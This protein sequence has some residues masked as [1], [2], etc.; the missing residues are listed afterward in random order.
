[1]QIRHL[2][3][4]TDPRLLQRAASRPW[5]RALSS[6]L[7]TSAVANAIHCAQ[8]AA[9][10]GSDGSQAGLYLAAMYVAI[11]A[12]SRMRRPSEHF[13]PASGA[14]F[15]SIRTGTCFRTGAGQCPLMRCWDGTALQSM[16]RAWPSGFH[17]MKASRAA[18]C[19]GVASPEAQLPTGGGARSSMG[20]ASRR[21]I[22]M[23]WKDG[24]KIL[25]CLRTGPAAFTAYTINT[26]NPINLTFWLLPLGSAP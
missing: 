9:R 16:R 11:A 14:S 18:A 26:Y 13:D 22:I 24:S 15:G 12:E 20:R 21:H 2:M 5:D 3:H 8:R 23:A 17:D 19:S 25:F 10:S 4:R 6:E 7:L 1:M